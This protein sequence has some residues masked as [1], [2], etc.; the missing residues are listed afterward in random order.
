MLPSEVKVLGKA[1]YGQPADAYVFQ[2]RLYTP[3]ILFK[4]KAKTDAA[5]H[6]YRRNSF[7]QLSEV[8]QPEIKSLVQECNTQP[9]QRIEP[10]TSCL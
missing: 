7:L 3:S 8:E 1:V 6:H 10:F 5:W 4:G 2:S 9:G